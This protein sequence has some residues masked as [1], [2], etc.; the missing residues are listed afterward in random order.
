MIINE[1]KEADLPLSTKLLVNHV[2]NSFDNFTGYFEKDF[3]ANHTDKELFNH[4]TEMDWTSDE[5]KQLKQLITSEDDE[6]VDCEIEGELYIMIKMMK[7]KNLFKRKVN[8]EPNASASQVTQEWNRIKNWP[9]VE[10]TRQLL[11]KAA[12]NEGQTIDEKIL[13]GIEE[14]LQDGLNIERNQFIAVHVK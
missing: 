10:E 5:N 1:L 14:C 4:L 7:K 2:C 11:I 12:K 6:N 13:E 8:L 9:E 3:F